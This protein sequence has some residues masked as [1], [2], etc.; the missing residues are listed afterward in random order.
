MC[1]CIHIKILFI[2]IYNYI[3]VSVLA[4]EK[5]NAHI[6]EWRLLVVALGGKVRIVG[7]YWVWIPKGK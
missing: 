5:L 2:Y 3:C 4:S 7:E 6:R 1:I